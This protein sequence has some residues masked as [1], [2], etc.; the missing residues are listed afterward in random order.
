M[1]RPGETW[2]TWV[3]SIMCSAELTERCSVILSLNMV[4]LLFSPLEGAVAVC[5]SAEFY[6]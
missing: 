2:N 5:I 6:E 1:T 3:G 4:S